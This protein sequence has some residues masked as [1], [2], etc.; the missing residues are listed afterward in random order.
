MEDLKDIISLG[1]SGG[2][3][4]RALIIAFAAIAVRFAMKRRIDKHR[5]W[6][7]RLFMVVS[8]VWFFRIGLMFWFMTTGGI[9]IDA[10]TF[11]GPFLTFMY[12]AQ[13]ALPLAVLQAYFNAQDGKAPGAKYAAAILVLFCTGITAAGIFAA[14]MGM[15]LPR[16]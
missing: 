4:I 3:I 11:E 12:F 14:A 9:G 13:M 1:F 5:R 2:D 7:M 10:K 16:I 8:A 15:W 6:A